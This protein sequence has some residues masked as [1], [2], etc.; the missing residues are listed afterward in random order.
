MSPG[1]WIEDRPSSLSCPVLPLA[2]TVR[3][4]GTLVDGDPPGRVAPSK[5]GAQLLRLPNAAA[6]L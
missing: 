1:G 2:V 6:I 4:P 3:H 5:S